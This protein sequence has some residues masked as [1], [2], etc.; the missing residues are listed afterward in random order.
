VK[1]VIIIPSMAEKA[2][3]QTA[4]ESVCGHY[5]GKVS[6]VRI[7]I[8][9]ANAL[10]ILI[11]HVR[12]NESDTVYKFEETSA[13]SLTDSYFV[14]VVDTAWREQR[15]GNSGEEEESPFKDVKEAWG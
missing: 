8:E 4:A 6:E 11:E 2:Q 5:S 15:L 3:I 9:T 12:S 10:Q 1:V 14:P 7:S 13:V